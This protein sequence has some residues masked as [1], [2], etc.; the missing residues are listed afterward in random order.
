MPSDSGATPPSA[1]DVS[2]RP[3][4]VE[5]WRQCAGLAVAHDQV[6]FIAPNVYSIAEAQFRPAAVPLAVYSADGVMVGFVMYGIEQ[7]AGRWKVFRLMVDRNH[8]RR[9]YG[10]AALAQ[11]LRRLRDQPGCRTVY[12]SY[13]D[14]NDAA[15]RLYRDFGFVEVER[16]GAK[17]TA[18]LDLQEGSAAHT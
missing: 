15:R 4:T 7:P 16:D 3:L 18:R 11:V 9:G 13:Q 6:T 17:V 2:L 1:T 10:R 12:I 14:A 8:Q 5:N